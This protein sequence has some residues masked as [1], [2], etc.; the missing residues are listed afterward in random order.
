M[1]KNSRRLRKTIPA[2]WKFNGPCVW[3]NM[4]ISGRML[5]SSS[6]KAAAS[7]D[8]KRYRPH[9]VGPFA[10]AMNLGERKTPA[11]IPISR[12]SIGTL[13]I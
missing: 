12:I 4:R 1:H 2:Q 13:R 5:K 6:S 7:E 8:R 9:F 11:C 10:R 3:D